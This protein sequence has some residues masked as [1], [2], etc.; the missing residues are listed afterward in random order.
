MFAWLWPTSLMLFIPEA[1]RLSRKKKLEIE[2]MFQEFMVALSA[3][4]RAGYSLPNGYEEAYKE[5][6]RLY[7]EKSFLV[8][9]LGRILRG[10][11]SGRRCEQMLESVGKELQCDSMEELGKTLQVATDVGGNMNHI[12]CRTIHALQQKYALLQDIEDAM[13]GRRYEAMIME[14]VPFA[15]VLYVEWTNPGFFQVLYTEGYGI[16]VMTV[17]FTM[18]LISKIWMQGIIRDAL[19][20]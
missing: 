20:V 13:A 10:T 12:L 19:E 14:I 15:L 7:G 18:Y 17:C 9:E 3:G 1:G 11:K 4:L 2:R 16:L 5:M 8:K 6:L